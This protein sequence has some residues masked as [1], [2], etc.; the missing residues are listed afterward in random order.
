MDMPTNYYDYKKY[1]ILYVDD[2]EKSLKYFKETFGEKFSV[3]TAPNAFEG[4]QLL[5]EHMAQTAILMTDQRMPG[6]KGIQLLEK[7]RLLKPQILAHH[8]DGLFGPGNRH[9]IGEHRRHL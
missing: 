4:Y 6:E 1:Y 3:L 8:G 7:A 5:R 9:R 2:E